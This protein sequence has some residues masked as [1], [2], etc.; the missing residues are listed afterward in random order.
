[1]YTRWERSS[2]VYLLLGFFKLTVAR[3]IE[4]LSSWKPGQTV[5]ESGHPACNSQVDSDERSLNLR[6]LVGNLYLLLN[7]VCTAIN[8][9]LL[10]LAIITQARTFYQYPETATTLIVVVTM[11]SIFRSLLFLADSVVQGQ[12]E[13]T[14]E[15]RIPGG[16]AGASCSCDEESDTDSGY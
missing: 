12:D 1:M 7:L 4:K 2:Y 9:M 10:P 15:L 16:N 6:E 14:T 3:L 5:F 13:E 8:N 11:R